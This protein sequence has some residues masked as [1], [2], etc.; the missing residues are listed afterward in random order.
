MRGYCERKHEGNKLIA[1]ADEQLSTSLA[2]KTLESIKI[3]SKQN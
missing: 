3:Y 1:L 2:I